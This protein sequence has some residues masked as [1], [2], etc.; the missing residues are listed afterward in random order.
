[1]L[2]LAD[3]GE[4][5][6]RLPRTAAGEG[7]AGAQFGLPY[8]LVFPDLPGDRWDA[9]RDL[10]AAAGRALDG[11]EPSRPTTPCGAGWPPRSPPRSPS[12]TGGPSDER[13]G[14]PAALPARAHVMG[15]ARL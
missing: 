4:L 12:S 8:T 7:R 5:L 3:V 1:M 2:A 10:L 15:P 9:H 13:P 6:T 14:L 11:I